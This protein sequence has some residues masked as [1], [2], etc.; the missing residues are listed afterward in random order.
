MPTREL[1]FQI[2]TVLDSLLK[3]ST[4]DDNKHWIVHGV[5]SGGESRKSEKARLR[6]GVSILVCTPGRLLDH[7]K[8]T[9]AF[10]NSLQIRWLVLDEADELL[11]LGFEETLSEILEI[12]GTVELREVPGL[13]SKRQTILCSATIEGGVEKLA[14]ETLVDPIF[15]NCDDENG[16]RS[17]PNPAETQDSSTNLT[18]NVVTTN[19]NTSTMPVELHQ[20]YV[21]SPAKLRLVNLIGLLKFISVRD[22]KI[23]VFLATGDSVDWHFHLFHN[24]LRSTDMNPETQSSNDTPVDKLES[25]EKGSNSTAP[26]YDDLPRLR[27]GYTSKLFPQSRLFKLH[28]S[29]AQSERNAVFQGYQTT[30]NAILFCTDVAARGIDV[31]DISHVVQYDP[32]GD[33]RDYVH[34]VGRTARLG[35]KGD[36]YCFLLPSEVDYLDLLEDLNCTLKEQPTK[37]L[38]ETLIPL[39]SIVF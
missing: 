25:D 18:S 24:A 36:A 39:K 33:V 3:Y 35:R 8:T 27:E 4:K 6:K 29:M 13:P 19:T 7:L 15:I 30:Q 23:I 22:C 28:G 26:V 34:R 16:S 37:P 12:L 5:C 20:Y 10:R 14:K 2:S 17:N 38:L 11:H 9:E 31:P 21:L 1:V 32:P